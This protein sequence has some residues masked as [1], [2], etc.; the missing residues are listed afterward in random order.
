[1]LT[2]ENKADLMLHTDEIGAR[3][4]YLNVLM[5]DVI[6]GF[7]MPLVYGEHTPA[8][9]A[10]IEAEPTLT[11]CE[12]ASRFLG[13]IEEHHKALIPIVFTPDPISDHS[14]MSDAERE[15]EITGDIL[16]AVEKIALRPDWLEK[17]KL[18]NYVAWEIA[19]GDNTTKT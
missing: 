8:T 6:E 13:E 2:N 11:K 9:L 5:R 17:L 14:A 10:K 12:M 15:A 16:K 18:L 1:M 19:T 7:M 4:E 3:L